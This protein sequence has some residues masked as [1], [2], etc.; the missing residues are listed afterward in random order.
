[1]LP[2]SRLSN[3]VSSPNLM[4]TTVLLWGAE[5]VASKQDPLSPD[6]TGNDNIVYNYPRAWGLL[7]LLKL[8]RSHV[9]AAGWLLAALLSATLFCLVPPITFSAVGIHAALIYS[10]PWLNAIGHGNGEILVV[11]LASFAALAHRGTP[12]VTMLSSAMLALASMLKVYPIIGFAV[13]ALRPPRVVLIPLLVGIAVTAGFFLD[14]A[15]IRT[16]IERTPQPA[17]N[18]F[19][20]TV[21]AARARELVRHDSRWLHQN[22]SIRSAITT[23]TGSDGVLRAAYL[24]LVSVALVAGF[25]SKSLTAGSPKPDD[26]LMRMGTFLFIGAFAIGA[27]WSYRLI[28]LLP[29][30]AAAARTRDARLVLSLL[31]SA[32]WL[33]ALS[34]GIGFVLEQAVMWGLGALLVFELGERMRVCWPVHRN[35]LVWV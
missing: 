6:L 19:G 27:S 10:P 22:G 9:I 33:G 13:L 20:V 11:A 15:H 7:G 14:F 30:I 23:A 35:T 26:M 28:V 24:A 3:V 5:R 12:R 1:M 29:S 25:R 16:V 34:S 17:H 8:T 32:F 18:A 31:L 4:D 21:I 2:T